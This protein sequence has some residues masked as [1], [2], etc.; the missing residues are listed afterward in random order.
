MPTTSSLSKQEY[1]LGL[2]FMVPIYMYKFSRGTLV[3]EWTTNEGCTKDV[4]TDMG[5]TGFVIY[6]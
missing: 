2:P 6:N 1:Q 3:V 4:G 5:K